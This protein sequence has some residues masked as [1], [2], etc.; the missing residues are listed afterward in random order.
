METSTAAVPVTQADAGGIATTLYL[1]AAVD[2]AKGPF[3]AQHC[4]R[5]LLNKVCADPILV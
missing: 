1:R 5:T 2:R 3:A 4:L